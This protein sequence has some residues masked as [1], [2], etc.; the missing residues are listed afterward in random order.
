MKWWKTLIGLALIA[1]SLYA[2]YMWNL[3]GKEAYAKAALE[4]AER[5][6]ALKLEEAKDPYEEI[7]EEGMSF[8]VI[9]SDW[10]YSKSSKLKSGAT[11]GIYSMALREKFGSF[12]VAF[13][14]DPSIEIICTLDDY[15]AINDNIALLRE[16]E[17]L[18]D[19]L[20]LVMEAS[21]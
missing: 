9:P 16:S 18:S 13:V 15:Y 12:V 7:Y 5:E 11:V 2:M 19:D 6:E 3:K 4:A 14:S 1:L 8:Y 17:L 21:I 20:L 10:I